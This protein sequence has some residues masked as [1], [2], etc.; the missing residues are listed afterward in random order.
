MKKKMARE[1]HTWQ[2]QKAKELKGQKRTRT[3]QNGL[4]SMSERLRPTKGKHA[5]AKLEPARTHCN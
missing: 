5:I 4:E 1:M 2:T 3:L